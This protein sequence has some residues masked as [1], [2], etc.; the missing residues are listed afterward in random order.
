VDLAVIEYN[1]RVLVVADWI[2]GV[3]LSCQIIDKFSESLGIE[4]PIDYFHM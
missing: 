4:T 2:I 1:Y 3:H